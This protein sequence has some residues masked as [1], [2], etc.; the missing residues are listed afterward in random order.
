MATEGL[1]SCI[2]FARGLRVAVTQGDRALCREAGTVFVGAVT[3]VPTFSALGQAAKA[4][5]IPAG[6]SLGR[7]PVFA[8][9]PGITAPVT[10]SNVGPPIG[11]VTF[12][13]FSTDVYKASARRGVGCGETPLIGTVCPIRLLCSNS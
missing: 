12:G 6:A 9:L 10:R 2:D 8:T 5:C 13:C 3:P 7:Q 11:F 4:T 1:P